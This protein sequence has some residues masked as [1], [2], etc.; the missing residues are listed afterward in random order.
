[1]DAWNLALHASPRRG[2]QYT[3][4]VPGSSFLA[5]LDRR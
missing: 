4:V 1:M 5:W 2:A 3:S